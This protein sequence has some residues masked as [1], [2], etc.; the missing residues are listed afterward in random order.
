[1]KFIIAALLA[2][3]MVTPQ[4]A[5]A[6][7]VPVA[8][9]SVPKGSVPQEVSKLKTSKLSPGEIR[10][11]RLLLTQKSDA[12]VS[13]VWERHDLNLLREN[14][15]SQFNYTNAGTAFWISMVV[16]SISAM[17]GA[18]AA[19]GGGKLVFAASA[20]SGLLTSSIFALQ[21]GHDSSMAI[22]GGAM[23]LSSIF[24]P[25]IVSDF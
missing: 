2:F 11:L 4:S 8:V 24:L 21:V 20:G 5:V 7:E 6:Q 14:P 16:I 25:F 22:V 18:S 12:E 15:P 19:K 3:G 23:V 17:A 10:S 9:K 1:M 13:P